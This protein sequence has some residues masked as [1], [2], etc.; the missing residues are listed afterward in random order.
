MRLNKDFLSIG[1]ITLN[2]LSR[3]HLVEFSSTIPIST[4]LILDY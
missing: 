1:V 2:T 3:T 4:D